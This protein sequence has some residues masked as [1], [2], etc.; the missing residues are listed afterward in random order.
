VTESGR[1]IDIITAHLKS[2]LLTFGG[3]FST[4]DET[5]RARTAYFA[6][7]RRAGPKPRASANAPPASSRL[8]E[9]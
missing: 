4:N 9:T 6:L 7:C 3:N 1:Q 2:K 5:L 8:A